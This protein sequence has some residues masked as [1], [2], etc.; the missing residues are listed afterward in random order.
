MPPSPVIKA[1]HANAEVVSTEL[2]FWLLGQN[3]N[4][5]N[6]FASYD[7]LLVFSLSKAVKL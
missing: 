4:S 1:T 7:F 5:I 6:Q 2:Y 3:T